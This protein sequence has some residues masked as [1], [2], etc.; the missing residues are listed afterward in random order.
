[1]NLFNFWNCLVLVINRMISPESLT[2]VL[3]KRCDLATC[4]GWASGSAGA[5]AFCNFNVLISF[6][7]FLFIA[8][9]FVPIALWVFFLSHFKIFSLKP[10][11]KEKWRNQHVLNNSQRLLGCLFPACNYLFLLFTPDSFIRAWNHFRITCP[12]TTEYCI[13]KRSLMLRGLEE[14][15]SEPRGTHRQFYSETSLSSQGRCKSLNPFRIPISVQFL[16]VYRELKLG[17]L[18]HCLSRMPV[19]GSQNCLS[20]FCF[21]ADLALVFRK[22]IIIINLLWYEAKRRNYFSFSL[23]DPLFSLLSV[24]DERALFMQIQLHTILPTDHAKMKFYVHFWLPGDQ[25]RWPVIWGLWSLFIFHH[26]HLRNGRVFPSCF[27]EKGFF[28]GHPEDDNF[29]W[30]ANT[31]D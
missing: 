31:G 24:L 4:W 9:V 14:S 28:S 21:C 13:V 18:S 22:K 15:V 10:E 29:P 1:M 23:W 7:G 27:N 19:A 26:S 30:K 3:S 20:G 12:T 2:S 8:Q 5:Q 25:K 11:K 6:L 16:P 17:D